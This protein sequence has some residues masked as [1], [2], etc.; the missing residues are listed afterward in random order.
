M[1]LPQHDQGGPRFE[2]SAASH[3]AFSM[4]LLKFC[5]PHLRV[6]PP[7]TQSDSSAKRTAR[8]VAQVAG[9]RGR[10]RTSVARKERQIYSLLVLA[11]HPP[12][13]RDRPEATNSRSGERSGHKDHPPQT[14][15]ELNRTTVR[16]TL[17]CRKGSC[18][19]T[20][21]LALLSRGIRPYPLPQRALDPQTQLAEGFEPPTL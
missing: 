11:T 10:I 8:L 7:N 4:L 5:P 17:Q 2:A 9:G 18:P 12:V 19:K 16:G 1:E 13:L 15:P 14:Q 3:R 6:S 20:P 21:A